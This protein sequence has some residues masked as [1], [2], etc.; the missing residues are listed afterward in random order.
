MTFRVHQ[1]IPRLNNDIPCAPKCTTTLTMTSNLLQSVPQLNNDIPFAPKCTPTQQWHSLCTKVYPNSTRTFYVY[2]SVPTLH[3]PPPLFSFHHLTL[4]AYI[5]PTSCSLST[6][7]LIALRYGESETRCVDWWIVFGITEECIGAIN[8]FCW[9]IIVVWLCL[10]VNQ[11]MIYVMYIYVTA[12]H[13]ECWFID[14]LFDWVCLDRYI[15]T[16]L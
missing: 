13:A 14:W 7:A 12:I 16:F 5:L 3:C 2:Q 1:S 9:L 6:A 10:W 15:N 11:H 4:R 8:T